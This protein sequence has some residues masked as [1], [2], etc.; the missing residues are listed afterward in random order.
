M[1]YLRPIYENEYSINDIQKFP[2]MFS[3]I[4]PLQDDEEDVLYDYELLFINIAKEETVNE[5]IEQIYVLK[6]L[7][8][9]GSNFQKIIDNS[10]YRMYF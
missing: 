2:S 1:D 8:P 3:L 10:T 4:T 6:K 7:M 9:I 5:I